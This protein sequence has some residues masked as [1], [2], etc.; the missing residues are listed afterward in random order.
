MNNKIQQ[1][2]EEIKNSKKHAF[3]KLIPATTTA[4]NDIAT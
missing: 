4:R 2:W 3:L 1:K